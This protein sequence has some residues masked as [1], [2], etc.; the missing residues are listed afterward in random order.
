MKPKL[1]R[2]TT[3]PESL[4]I[5]LRGQHQFMSTNGFEVIG[6]SSAGDALIEVS[7][8]EEIKVIAINM[9]RKITPI[10]DFIS[11]YKLYKQIKKEKPIM[12]H[13]HTPKAG[14]V[15]MLAAK[16]ANVPIR[17]HTVA[18]LPLMEATGIKRKVLNI[19]EKITYACATKVYPNSKGLYDFIVEEKLASSRKLKIIANGSSNGIDTSYF[20]LDSISE[21][22]MKEFRLKLNIQSKDFVF[23][24]VGRLVGDKGINEL[25]AA[26][27]RFKNL[28][29]KLLL[30]G[31][32]ES[33]L[34]PLNR[35]TIQKI[36]KNENIISVGFQ[37]DVRPYFAISHCLVF[38]SYRE[39]FPNVVL[40][41]GAMELPS[42]VSNI[43]GCNEI[44]KE[45]VNGIVIPPKN[46]ESLYV[47]MKIMI[48][49]EINRKLL[50]ANA[51]NLI[52]SRYEQ[53]F[54]W[55]ALLTEY[56]SLLIDKG[57]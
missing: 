16:I 26:F 39:G 3:V 25:I 56:K 9:S 23:V 45:G 42:I 22:Q 20:N 5:L 49:N 46:I 28:N 11:V 43:N 17:I 24:F 41:A 8:K 34:D 36:H 30:V 4:N 21:Q 51:R 44:I 15:T 18:G 48:N 38:P 29:I 53:Q 35:D 12:V 2:V 10:S 47:A 31:G 37:K 55:D 19:V 7:Q 14:I 27:S 52:I 32:L 33:D 57:L 40:Q 13:S 54:V 50:A 1:F 6:I